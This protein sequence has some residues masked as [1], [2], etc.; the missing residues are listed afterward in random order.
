MQIFD[1]SPGNAIDA[2][3]QLQVDPPK[4]VASRSQRRILLV[5]LAHALL[6]LVLIQAP[7]LSTIHAYSV[8]ILGALFALTKTNICVAYVAAYVV[9]SEVLWRMTEASIFW[10]GGK[11]AVVL[12]LGLSI[13]HQRKRR[14][15]VFPLLYFLLLLPS[16]LFTLEVFDIF[17]AREAISFNLSGPLALFVSS[18]FF[19]GLKFNRRQYITILSVLVM[20]ILTIAMYAL[21][22]TSMMDSVEWSNESMFATSGGFGP[23]QVSTMMGLGVIGSVLILLYGKLGRVVGVILALLGA[24]FLAQG[25]LTFSRGGILAAVI[26]VVLLNV[27]IIITRKLSAK[28]VFASI[29]IIA[30]V[31]MVVL[32]SIDNFT[33]GFL[34]LRY[35]DLNLSNRDQ[36]ASVEISLF[37]SQPITGVGPGLGRLYTDA[38]A[39]T[40]FVRLLSEHGI[41]GAIGGLSLCAITLSNY[42]RSA[43]TTRPVILS[44]AVWP[45]ITMMHSAMRLAGVSYIF[46]LSFI[47]VDFEDES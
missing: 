4:M 47:S 10:E 45:L 23:N 7:G 14:I 9:G 6:G 33:Q 46:G 29:A 5:F 38:A 34:S 20:P 41:L 44:L 16:S 26:V 25:L 8:I 19:S 32:P 30:L 12:I 28:Y 40:E 18:W 35:A 36:I 27:H 21:F 24:V 2:N 15:P 17:T 37:L 3:Y 13:L 42:L 22:Q 31:A 11:Y 43:P 1:T 39:H